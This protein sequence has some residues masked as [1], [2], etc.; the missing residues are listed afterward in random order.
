MRNLFKRSLGTCLILVLVVLAFEVAFA[1]K[2]ELVVQTGHPSDI[3]SVA[4]SPDGQLLASVGG[5]W[6]HTMKLWDVA[7]GAELH[8]FTGHTDGI[9]AV[10]FSPNGQLLASGSSDNTIKLWDITTGTLIRTLAG[11]SEINSLAFS[12]DGKLLASGNDDNTIRLWDVSTGRNLA[13]FTG[14]SESPTGYSVFILSIAFS[15]DGKLLASGSND[16]IIELWIVDTGQHLRTLSGLSGYVYSVPFSPDGRLLAGGDDEGTIKLWEVSSGKALHTLSGHMYGVH[17]VA[18]SPNSKLLASGGRVTGG[19]TGDKMIKLWEV[20]S[21]KILRTI[22]GHTEGVSSVAFSPDGKF[23]ASGSADKT[24]RLWDMSTGEL[25]RTLSGHAVPVYSIA[26]NQDW[27][28]LAH[29]GGD[30]IVRLWDLNVDIPLRTLVGHSDFIRSLGFSSN[31][32]LLVSGSDDG[33]TKFWNVDTGTTIQTLSGKN[34]VAFSPDN[35]TVAGSGDGR[36]KLWDVSTGKISRIF[37]GTFDDPI[38]FSPDGKILAHGET[39]GNVKV[40]DVNTG[41]ALHTLMGHSREADRTNIFSV[42][43]SPDGK[44]IA[45]GNIDDTIDLWDVNTGAALHTFIR[46]IRVE[47]RESL[48]TSSIA[49]SPDG[50]RL[51]RGSENHTI[52]LWDV[53]TEALIHT[54]V[55]HS[56]GISSVAFSPDGKLLASGSDDATIKLWEVSSGKELVSLIAL[57]QQDWVAVTPDGRFDG[58]PDGMKLMHYVQNNQP[59][60]LDAFFEQFYT[61]KLLARVLSGKAAPSTSTRVDFSKAIKLPPLVRI[62]SP[63]AGESFTTDQ[64]S[65]TVEATDQGGGI[66]E[67]RLYQNGKLVSEE[68]RGMK[69]VPTAGA[70]ITK[71]YQ[72]ILLPGLNAFRA[73]AFNT[74]RTESSP[75]EL[76]ID[77]KAAQ[78]SANLYILAIGINTYQNPK[79]SLNYG[80]PDAQAFADAVE[81]RGRG[82]FLR[83]EKQLLFDAQATR[84]A[85]EAALTRVIAQAKP[86]D[87]FVFYYAGHGVMSE[88]DETTPSDFYLIPHDITQLYGNDA[89]LVS[90][91]IS[92]KLLKEWCRKIQAQKQMIVLDACQSGGAVE[93]FA[94]RG[95]AEEKAILQ[96]ARS[97]GVVVLASTETAQFATEFGKLGHGVFTYALLQGLSGDADGTPRDG[98]VTVKELEAYLNDTVPELTKQYRG[99]AQYPNSYARGQDFPLGVVP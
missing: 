32:K 54:F 30:S 23:L 34:R 90:K 69:P 89:L 55:G 73:T 97:A 28:F 50:K 11:E 4:F 65:L 33:T 88:G 56:G 44:L 37:N 53:S 48:S 36:I 60:P 96:L 78:A 9:F 95:A 39:N 87:A 47:H 26:C 20:S 35:K 38:A 27:K 40:W 76:T 82:V 19:G 18:F 8:T 45:N 51:A 13:T 49:F 7:T 68:Q 1:Q 25:I 43:F 21:G 86:Q 77:L 22:T 10:A 75:A 46:P 14:H 52:S 80:R 94:L 29:A 91:G 42:T 74:D 41:T 17:C 92:A 93:T 71:T 66:D 63:K 62:S 64:I 5:N 98:K 67:V 83:I 2:P 57:D 85:I 70:K 31:G 79:Y 16:G 84:G 72:V 15:P 12:P 6:E 58:S 81:Q 24:I 61:P 59:I 99:T 3:W